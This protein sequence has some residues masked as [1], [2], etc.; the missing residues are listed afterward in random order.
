[1]S[2]ATAQPSACGPSTSQ[3]KTGTPAS[4]AT[5]I[6]LGTV[7]MRPCWSG[8]AAAVASGSLSARVTSCAPRLR[9]VPTL[10]GRGRCP[11]APRPADGPPGPPGKRRQIFIDYSPVNLKYLRIVYAGRR[12]F[13]GGQPADGNGRQMESREGSMKLI[14]VISPRPGGR[15][16][17]R[18]P[19]LAI[20]AAS[21]SLLFPL[22]AAALASPAA[23]STAPASTVS[24]TRRR[25]ARHRPAPA[26]GQP[27]GEPQLSL[28]EP[29][30]A[31]LAAGPPAAV[32]DDPRQ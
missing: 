11:P 14:P 2:R 24:A 6:A 15:R 21:L 13:R 1:M 17:R 4:R 18:M 3:R 19:P 5:L 25:L 8:R 16:A 20:I 27:G 32:E 9:S 23:A 29:V 7:R 30:T 26:T 31:H 22:A 28:A 10:P 12:N